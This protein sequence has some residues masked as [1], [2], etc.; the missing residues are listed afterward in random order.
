MACYANNSTTGDKDC[1]VN[2]I[3]SGSSQSSSRLAAYLIGRGLANT[4]QIYARLTTAG[5]SSSS[6]YAAGVA[7]DYSTTVSGATFT[8]WYLP[9]EDEL[10]EMW[11][12]R[13]RIGDLPPVDYWTST[14]ADPDDF[15]HMYA[16]DGSFYTNGYSKSDRTRKVRPIRAFAPIP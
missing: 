16:G 10:R 14:E 2:S 6:T 15:R 9:S 13:S 12:N 5:G 8:D 11:V 3:Y 4:N 7:Y 1:S